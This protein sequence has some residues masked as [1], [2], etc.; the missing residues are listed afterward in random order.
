MTDIIF[1][2]S[3]IIILFISGESLI[4]GSV[5]LASILKVPTFVVAVTIVSFGTS[6][7][8]LAISANASFNGYSGI[9]IGNVVGSNIANVLL[10][11]PLSMLVKPMII[12]GIKK[13]DC[14]F[15]LISTAIY[16]YILFTFQE[17]NHLFGII[18]LTSLLIYISYV[19]IDAKKGNRMNEQNDDTQYGLFKSLALTTLGLFGV[20]IGSE[21][22]VLGAINL[23]RTIGITEVIIGLSVVAIGSS[24]PEVI[25]S[26]VA[27]I[28]GSSG[29]L[30]GAIIGSNLFN[31]LGITGIASI[32]SPIKIVNTVNHS[33]IYMLLFSTLILIFISLIKRKMYRV[34]SLFLLLS[35]ATYVTC[36]YY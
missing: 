3:G 28:R 34:F 4:R 2:I 21:I 20:F 26:F 11:I 31:L 15:L 17:L 22:L 8:E 29:F 9:A 1:V 7:P 35:H 12:S 14:I 10:A 32:I 36:L 13:T 25:T 6:A 33:D 16:V 27:A 19:V 30:V 5:S 23:A 18:M 24:L